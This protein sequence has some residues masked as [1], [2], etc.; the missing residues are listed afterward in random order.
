MGN[1]EEACALSCEKWIDSFPAEIPKHKFSKKHTEKIEEIFKTEPIKNKRKLSKKTVKFILIAAILLSLTITAFAVPS[2]RKFIV[3]K[4]SNHS[5]YTVIDT[6]DA[7]NVTSLKLGY[8]PKG[9]EK[10]EEYKSNGFYVKIYKNFDKSFTVEKHKLS[11]YIDFD[12]EKN[13]SENIEINGIN[14]VYYK[15]DNEVKGIIFNNRDYIFVVEGN[16][17]K[18]ELVDIAQNV[19]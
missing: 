10:E 11:A 8:I 16:I 2:S 18:D 3:E 19:D 4:F 15:S 9:F 13:N 7:E 17:G 5:E 14:A 12:T 6:D 1:F